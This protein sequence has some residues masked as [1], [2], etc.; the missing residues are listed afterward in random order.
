MLLTLRECP[1]AVFTARNMGLGASWNHYFI[2]LCYQVGA[3]AHTDGRYRTMRFNMIGRIPDTVRMA[4]Q[5][6]LTI[7]FFRNSYF[8][9]FKIHN[10]QQLCIQKVCKV[11]SCT[12]FFSRPPRF[13]AHVCYSRGP[14]PPIAEPSSNLHMYTVTQTLGKLPVQYLVWNTTDAWTMQALSAA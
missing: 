6:E 12:D 13:P 1:F 4:V 8:S 11:Y 9:S 14:V 3:R 7:P 5:I 2:V 10:T